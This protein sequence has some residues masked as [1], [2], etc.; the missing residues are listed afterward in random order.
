MTKGQ[1]WDSLIGVPHR[2]CCHGTPSSCTIGKADAA[3]T[4]GSSG[5]MYSFM[6]PRSMTQAGEFNW[7]SQVPCPTNP[8]NQEQD[9]LASH[10]DSHN[11]VSSIEKVMGCQMRKTNMH[12]Y[13]HTYI[14]KQI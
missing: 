12:T 7:L 10:Q 4:H 13:L 6:S 1:L 5:L 14:S 9:H 11:G 3:V 8:T 2:C